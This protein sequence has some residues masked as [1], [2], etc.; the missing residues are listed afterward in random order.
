MV[1]A[2]EVGGAEPSDKQEWRAALDPEKDDV[3]GVAAVV[4]D[5]RLIQLRRGGLDARQSLC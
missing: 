2:A 3:E 5:L 4:R 1:L